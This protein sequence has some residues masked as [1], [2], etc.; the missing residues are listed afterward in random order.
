MKWVS[1]LSKQ[2]DIDT[3]VQE[4]TEEII[5]QLE[6]EEADLTIIFIAPQYKDF[7]DK[8]PELINRYFKPGMLFGCSGGGIIG[9]GEE[10]EQQAAFSLTCA[11]TVSYT[12]LTLPTIYSV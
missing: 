11:K 9:N 3:A 10:A 8:V 4:A 2:A 7:Y 1:A 12:H 5:R 6:G